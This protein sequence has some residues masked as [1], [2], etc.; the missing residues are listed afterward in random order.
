MDLSV[1]PKDKI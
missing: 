1:S